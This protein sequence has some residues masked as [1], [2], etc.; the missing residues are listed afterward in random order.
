MESSYTVGNGRKITVKVNDDGSVAVSGASDVRMVV[1]YAFRCNEAKYYPYG[2]LDGRM[3]VTMK[4]PGE[5]EGRVEVAFRD[6]EQN[7]LRT[8]TFPIP[9]PPKPTALL[10]EFAY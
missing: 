3:E 2:T 10:R 9:V 5:E 7:L 8:E 6:S 4:A 1:P